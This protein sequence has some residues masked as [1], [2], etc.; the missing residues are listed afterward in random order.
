MDGYCFAYPNHFTLQDQPS[1]KP[2]IRG[3]AVDDSMEPIHATFS[4]EVI[5]AAT[6]QT[7]REQAES[8]LREL[9][10]MD[11][12][13]FKWTQVQIGGEAGWKV[14]P[15]PVMLARRVVFVQHNGYLFRLSYWPVDIPEAQTD[16]DELTQTT[17]ASFAFTK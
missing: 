8:F 16:L 13:T 17:L 12:A 7:L 11:P 9:S 4:V 1:D 2:E 14:E 5:P 6:D 3:S 15:V 10:V